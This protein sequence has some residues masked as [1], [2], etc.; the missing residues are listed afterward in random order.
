MFLVRFVCLLVV[1]LLV[2]QQDYEKN[3]WPDFD[4][5]W[6]ESVAWAKKELLT[7]WSRFESQ[8]KIWIY[9]FFLTFVNIAR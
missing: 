9:L 4:E 8:D 1:C 3:Y 7:F 2:H 5:T 6:C